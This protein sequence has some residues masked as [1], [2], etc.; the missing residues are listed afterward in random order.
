MRAVLDQLGYRVVVTHF[1][2]R[3]GYLVRKLVSPD[4]IPTLMIVETF[5]LSIVDGVLRS[6]WGGK[7]FRV[8][9]QVGV[10]VR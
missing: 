6:G 5:A 8:A 3:S 4:V 10:T 1:D 2:E 9:R 7:G